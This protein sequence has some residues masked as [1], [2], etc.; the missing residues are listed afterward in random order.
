M[1]TFRIQKSKLKGELTI[2]PSKSHTVRAI[3]FAAFADG[4]STIYNYLAS[5]DTEAMVNA[6]R[7]FGATLH[8]FPDR[9][10]VVGTNG[11]IKHAE[12][13]IHAGNSGLTFRFATA[14]GALAS[15]PVVVTGDYS[16]RH[17][18]PIL[19]LLEGLSQLGVKTASM[20]G[21]NHAPVIVQGPIRPGAAN[22]ESEDAQYASS[23]IIAS[24]FA[25]GPIEI[26]VSKA[27][28]KPWIDVT[29][30]WLDR[31][32]IPYERKGYDYY[33]LEGKARYKGFEYTVPGDFS[34]A[35]FPIAAA[36]ITQ[37][38]LRLNNLD[39]SDS[40]GDKELIHQFCKMGAAIEIDTTNHTIWVRKGP[41]LKGMEI[42]INDF[43]DAV[44]ILAVV[45]CFAEGE[46]L[47]HNAA[48]VKHKECNRLACISSELKKMGA[49]ITPTD[50]GLLIRKSALKGSHLH[51]YHD[52]RMALSLA[53]AAMTAEE[54]STITPID[55]V[56]K[57]F[58]TFVQDFTT[59][60]AK[61]EIV[62]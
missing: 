4:C 21:D 51:S 26:F 50:D 25:E 48:V 60:G 49:D 7:L 24:A 35:A 16:I 43:V 38:E 32:G 23:L 22:I 47:I 6:C 3:L 57:T 59:L 33:R 45:G 18:R 15:S 40:Q 5:P 56:A 19:P 11:K 58:P 20:R 13:V 54:P 34:T 10:E 46:T 55:C 27:G 39:M 28:E 12:D 52:H 8:I 1:S 30:S 14:L 29:L 53:V 61:I 41:T 17:Y 36:L 9:I 31:L 44:T 42:D 2:P 37:S 62:S